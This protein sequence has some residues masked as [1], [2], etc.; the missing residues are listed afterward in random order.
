VNNSAQVE[1]AG[2]TAGSSLDPQDLKCF[3]YPTSRYQ[4]MRKK[5][6]KETLKI[7]EQIFLK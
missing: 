5:N 1:L 7:T 2:V 6:T 4:N 3:K